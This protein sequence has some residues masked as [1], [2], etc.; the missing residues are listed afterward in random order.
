MLLAKKSPA[1]QNTNIIQIESYLSHPAILWPKIFTR[2]LTRK[3]RYNIGS[4]CLREKLREVH[5]NCAYCAH[6]ANI[7]RN[8]RNILRDFSRNVSRILR[9]FSRILRESARKLRAFAR[10]FARISRIFREDSHNFRAKARTFAH[11]SRKFVPIWRST[12]HI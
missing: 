4:P 8:A 7:A 11:S 6:W 9:D 12:S 2:P 5:E 3:R 10:I 1:R